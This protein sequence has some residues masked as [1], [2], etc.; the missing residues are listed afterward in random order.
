M[1]A[2]EEIED[3]IDRAIKKVGGQQENDLCKYIPMTGGGYMHHFTLRKMK[4]KQ[5]A[6]LAGLIEQF[7][8]NATKPSGIAPKQRAPRGSRKRKDQIVF[9]K[10]QLDHL[11]NLARNSG[12]REL[13]SV[14]SPKKS[15]AACKRE[16][17]SSIR[18]NVADQALWAMFSEMVS[19]SHEP[20]S[21]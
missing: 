8:I 5:P 10:S 16:L 21:L 11:L 17:I 9:T 13:M 7:I 4:L 1:K 18:Q 6:E 12:N 15:I 2:L 14:L 20:S 19:A 3:I